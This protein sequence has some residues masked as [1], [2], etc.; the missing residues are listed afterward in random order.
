MARPE[1]IHPIRLE[2]LNQNN[3]VETAET[4]M[5]TLSK[6]PNE[7]RYYVN[8]IHKMTTTKLRSLLTLVNRVENLERLESGENL[9]DELIQD[10]L[11]AQI[12]FAYEAGRENSVKEF[13]EL[14]QLLNL[15]KEVIQ[16]RT[17][18]K[19]ELFARYFESLV[20]YHRFFGGR[21][22]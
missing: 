15:L 1:N 2:N 11:H 17:K 13:L 4:L 9:S 8:P 6:V 3:Y 7:A 12:R 19:F 22:E 18:A 14:S 21:S 20:A 16:N 5:K 10:L